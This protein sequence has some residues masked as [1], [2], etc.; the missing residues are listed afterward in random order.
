MYKQ[1]HFY[2]YKSRKSTKIKYSCLL[3][4]VETCVYVFENR[5]FKSCS[6]I[7]I[8]KEHD[9]KLKEMGYEKPV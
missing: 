3:F 8:Y 7:N 2:S 4:C 1:V 6:D 5:L 9:Y